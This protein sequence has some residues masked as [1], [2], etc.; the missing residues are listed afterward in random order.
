MRKGDTLT[1]VA[2]AVGVVGVVRGEV[3]ADIA[4]CCCGREAGETGP[5][6][7]VEEGGAGTVPAADVD[8]CMM[9]LR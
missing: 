8:V 5:A 4:L 6:V 1:R 2:A 3:G 7:D 9:S